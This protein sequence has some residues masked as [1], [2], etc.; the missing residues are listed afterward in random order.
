[1]KKFKNNKILDRQTEKN[2]LKSQ[3]HDVNLQKNTVLYFQIGLILCLLGVYGAL[4]MKFE[5]TSYPDIVMDE[6]AQFEEFSLDKLNFTIEEPQKVEQTQKVELPKE[7]I[8]IVEVPDDTPDKLITDN[9]VTDTNPK[10][11]HNINPNDFFV[12]K[13]IEDIQEIVNVNF[14]EQVPI[15]P[16]CENQTTNLERKKCLSE[17]LSKL[18]R[19]KFDTGLGTELGLKE[20]V[21]KI[22]VNFKIDTNGKAHVLKTRAAHPKLEEEAKKVVGQIPTM[23]PGKQGNN[24]VSVLYTLPIAF[25]VKY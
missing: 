18:V 24:N 12:E 25:Q 19:K 21:Q 16:G 7:L 14:V 20:G 2:V 4:E 10:P 6:D 11:Q 3:K 1:M 23:Q 13:P 17:Q 8:D 15:Y 9:I 22:Y 5:T